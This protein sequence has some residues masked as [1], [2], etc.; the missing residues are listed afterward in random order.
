MQGS[1]LLG[2]ILAV[3]LGQGV[4]T[5]PLP[6]RHANATVNRTLT[7]VDWPGVCSAKLCFTTVILNHTEA[8]GQKTAK[9]A[10]VPPQAEQPA[11]TD[12]DVA[13]QH[14]AAQSLRMKGYEMLPWMIGCDLEWPSFHQ[15]TGLCEVVSE[16]HICV[17]MSPCALPAWDVVEPRTGKRTS[18]AH[19]QT[20]D[21]RPRMSQTQRATTLKTTSWVSAATAAVWNP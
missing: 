7:F 1:A 4:N 21:S 9:S 10:E 12:D 5:E 13:W 20:S 19:L 14:L 17:H 8:F 16:T 3:L 6:Q 15:T 18:A 2:L 11:K